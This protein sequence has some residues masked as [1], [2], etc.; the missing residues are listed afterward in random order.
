MESLPPSVFQRLSRFD[1]ID[2]RRLAAGQPLDE[3]VTD[4]GD[5]LRRRGRSETHVAMS[6]SRA[7]RVIAAAGARY[8]SD[9]TPERIERALAKV[10]G[11]DSLA[12]KTR[13]AYLTGLRMFANW[14]T[15]PKV[16]RAAASPAE[17]VKMQAVE[18]RE[19][20]PGVHDR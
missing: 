2:A 4:F 18:E 20:P 15:S 13:N 17:A 7:R 11:D 8:W 14:M 3:H 6:L 10:Q 5:D 1:L 16:R 9:L 12:P 19:Y